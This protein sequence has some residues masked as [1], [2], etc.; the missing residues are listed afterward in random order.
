MWEQRD[1]RSRA[2]SSRCRRCTTSRPSRTA[3]GTRRCG[4]RRQPA[5][6][7][8]GG[9]DGH[10][11]DALNFEPIHNLKGW[12]E[13]YKEAIQSPTDQIGQFKNDNVMMTNAVVR[14]K[15]RDRAEI[16]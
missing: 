15:D 13:A 10:R 12:V 7:R 5:D 6:V 14:L 3:A 16:G 11:R 8:Q 9:V 4:S 2:S 1:Y